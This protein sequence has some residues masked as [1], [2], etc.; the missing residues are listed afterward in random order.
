MATRHICDQRPFRWEGVEFTLPAIVDLHELKSLGPLTLYDKFWAFHVNRQRIVLEKIK[1]CLNTALTQY[2]NAVDIS[3][4]DRQQLSDGFKNSP[5]WDRV[6]D[7]CNSRI[8]STVHAGNQPKAPPKAPTRPAFLRKPSF[9]QW[10]IPNG[11]EPSRQ[12]SSRPPMQLQ[13]TLPNI[14]VHSIFM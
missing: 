10:H 13:V 14:S 8:N 1:S 11:L 2:I 3:V 5:E 6:L 7:Q 9:N 12:V 4:P